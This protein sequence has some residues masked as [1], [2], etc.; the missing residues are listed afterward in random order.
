MG[1]RGEAA[2]LSTLQAVGSEG[3]ASPEKGSEGGGQDE[4]ILGLTSRIWSSVAL[5]RG[6]ASCL[7]RLQ[8]RNLWHGAN[9]RPLA[10]FS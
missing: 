7:M 4:D 5:Q 10:C 9:C 3:A 2:L 1:P 6:A 8:F